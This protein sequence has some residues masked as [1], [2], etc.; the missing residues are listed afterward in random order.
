MK[1]KQF[2]ENLVREM[3]AE[4]L[5]EKSV[6]QQQQK[7]MALAYSVKKGKT[8]RTKVSQKVLDIADG[9][10]ETELKKFATTDPKG[11]PKRVSKKK[12]N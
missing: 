8:P 10:S 11:L 4:I 12:T 9:M 3:I 6:S 1:N 2:I 7:L 5:S